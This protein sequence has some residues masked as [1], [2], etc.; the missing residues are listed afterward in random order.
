MQ[1]SVCSDQN[2]ST[3]AHYGVLGMKWGVRKEYELK[4]QKKKNNS[5]VDK[6]KDNRKTHTYVSD[7]QKDYNREHAITTRKTDK[8]TITIDHETS[9]EKSDDKEFI[10]S[11]FA[12]KTNPVK[13]APAEEAQKKFDSLPKT[14]ETWRGDSKECRILNHGDALTHARQNNCYECTLAYEARRRGYNV[15]ANECPGGR[16]MD[17]F[18]AFDVVDKIKVK[19]SPL[20]GVNLSNE[21]KAEIC[22]SEIEKKCLSY[23]EG[24]RGMLGISYADF[25][26][27]HAMT[28]LIENGEFKI[29][30][31][32]HGGKNGKTT[33][34]KCDAEKGVD[35]C[36]LDNADILPGITDYVDPYKAEANEAL[37]DKMKLR[38]TS[39]KLVSKKEVENP[40]DKYRREQKEKRR[41]QMGQTAVGRAMLK[42]GDTAAKAASATKKYIKKGIEAVNK[43]FKKLF[44]IQTKTISHTDL[45]QTW[46]VTK[47]IRRGQDDYVRRS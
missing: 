2:V 17:I 7:A 5:L 30:D 21:E 9:A 8:A 42:I 33:F 22:Y 39:S 26:S 27:G 1:W 15:Q 11:E 14:D 31:P 23:G 19:V 13:F 6:I 44:N 34:L 25:D 43:A 18:H 4:G 46:V 36:R 38:N 32:Q 3:L 37:L 47:R 41:V 45:H 40:V 10:Y 16:S 35:V 24:A 12:I 20:D 29:I 28:W